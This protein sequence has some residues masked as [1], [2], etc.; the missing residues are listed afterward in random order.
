VPPFGNPGSPEYHTQNEELAA[1]SP[2]ESI[3][4]RHRHKSKHNKPGRNGK[5]REKWRPPLRKKNKNI[6]KKEIIIKT[7]IYICESYKLFIVDM[8]STFY[9]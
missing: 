4:S 3:M 7:F 9:Q 5:K 2:R 1:L 8:V 6:I